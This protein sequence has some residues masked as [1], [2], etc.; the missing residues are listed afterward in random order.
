MGKLVKSIRLNNLEYN[1]NRDPQAYRRVVGMP[2]RVDVFLDG[3]G[4]ARAKIEVDG[5]IRCNRSIDL[6][7]RLSCE[8]SLDS[9]GTRIATL[10]V[11]GAD[12]SYQRHFRLDVMAQAGVG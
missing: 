12:E 7:G 3:R 1:P 6:P 10:V 2:F 5:V 8:F 9:P 4:K 11:E